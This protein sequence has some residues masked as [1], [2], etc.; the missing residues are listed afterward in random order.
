MIV[1]NECTFNE[2]QMKLITPLSIDIG[3][4]KEALTA[5][6]IKGKLMEDMDN[7]NSRLD[8]YYNRFYMGDEK[9]VTAGTKRKGITPESIANHVSQV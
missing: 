4:D 3:K 1:A 7:I 9:L 6:T 8:A 5:A 2:Y